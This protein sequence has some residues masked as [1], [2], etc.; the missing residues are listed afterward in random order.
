MQHGTGALHID[1]TRLSTN[2]NLNGGAYAEN[3]SDRWDGA[4]N[5]RYK[6]NGGAGGYEQPTGRWP[7]N[8][9]LEHLPGCRCVGKKKVKNPSGPAS[10]PTK[11][12]WGTTGIYGAAY[13]E[14]D[15]VPFY[16]DGDGTEMVDAWDCE[17]GCPVADL[18]EQSGTIKGTIRQPTGKAI[19]PTEGTSMVWN[20]NSVMDNTTRGFADMG[21][22]SRFF[23]QVGGSPPGQDS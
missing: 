17:P 7:A 22:A 20:P 10:G 16:G 23:K 6:R 21:G 11:S 15:E 19:Y 18:D 14:R 4:E 1:A 13:G 2:D 9:I 5:W 3:G 8:L 12:A